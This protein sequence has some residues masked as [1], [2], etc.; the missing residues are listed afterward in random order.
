MKQNEKIAKELIKLAKNLVAKSHLQDPI[1]K[2]EYLH[3]LLIDLKEIG[4][5]N[6]LKS[7]TNLDPVFISKSIEGIENYC[8]NY[9]PLI[10]KIF[11]SL[12]DLLSDIDDIVIKQKMVD[13]QVVGGRYVPDWIYAINR[14]IDEIVKNYK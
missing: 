8:N 6:P 3:N 11:V 9:F 12:Q 5:E 2:A 4:L 1:K 13:I 10:T 14:I 7:N